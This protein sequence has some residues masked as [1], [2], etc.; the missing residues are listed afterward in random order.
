M[1]LVFDGEYAHLKDALVEICAGLGVS[2][3]GETA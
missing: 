2:D 1:P 3:T